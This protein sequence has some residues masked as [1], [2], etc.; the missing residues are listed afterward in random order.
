MARFIS[1]IISGNAKPLN[2]ALSKA[3]ANMTDFQKKVATGFIVAGAA[4]T[5]FATSAVKAAAKDQVV[6]KNLERQLRASAGASAE[7]IHQSEQ[8]LKS[9]GRA[10]AFGKTALVPGYQ[11]LVLATKD[12]TKA[13]SIMN[14]A[15]DTARARNLDV[16]AV[17][18]ALA[19]AYAGNTRGLRNL[20]PEM[21]KLIS[22]GASFSEVLQVL[23]KNFSGAASDYAQTFQG[24]LDVLNNSTAALKK[25]IGYA[26]LPVVEK[27]I[28]VFQSV[29]DVFAKSPGLIGAIAFGVGAMAAAFMAA[30]TAA[31]AW[32]AAAIIAEAVNAALATSFTTLQVATGGIVLV[33]SA[34]VAGYMALK[35]SKNETKD[36]TN[37]LTDALL[38]ENAAQSGVLAQLVA[39]NQE[40]E[41]QVTSLKELGLRFSDVTTY[42]KTGK[43]QFAKY[44]EALKVFDSTT[45]TTVEKLD[46]FAKAAGFDPRQRS[47]DSVYEIA[48][49]MQAL[50]NNAKTARTE[51]EKVRLAME[52]LKAVGV[53]SADS[54]DRAAAAFE[55]TKK[56][57]QEAR[58]AIRE[59]AGQMRDSFLGMISLSDAFSTAQKTQ[60]DATTKLNEALANRAEAYARLNKLEQDRYANARD[61]ADAQQD[62]ADAE[63]AVNQARQ[64]PQGPNYVELFRKQIEDAKK[65]AG[66]MAQLRGKGLS[67]TAVQQILALGPI[68]GAQV[69]Q[70][71]LSG[72]GGLTVASLNADLAAVGAAGYAVGTAGPGEQGV[73]S[74]T[75]VGAAGGGQYAIYVTS[76][77]PNAVVEA[78]KKYMRQNGAVP[79]K[80]TNR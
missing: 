67:S 24:R 60:D 59:Y 25:Q 11:S 10:S 75:R 41:R 47:A 18:E 37:E 54:Q 42:V 79:I 3:T 78:L 73:L 39:G 23:S 19:K 45:G 55:K 12:V 58:K 57:L 40:Y 1:V 72:A 14:I 5:A 63:D 80:V 76:A 51:S 29:V 48:Y 34:A 13:Q 22:E 46:A 38:A 53:D 2:S 50:A 17:S 61:L 31:I 27:L 9:A 15:L 65:F 44:V 7:Q 77:D 4:A 26:L 20:S 62:V 36:A 21:K 8:F 43:G 68:A 30:T 56:S 74:G 35:G 69:A 49:A 71:L 64:I 70:E 52:L 16:T 6:M 32:K 33:V 66:L 28:P